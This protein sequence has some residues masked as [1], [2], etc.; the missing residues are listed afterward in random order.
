MVEWREVAMGGAEGAKGFHIGRGP[1]RHR[2]RLVEAVSAT[3]MGLLTII[4]KSRR[5]EREMRILFL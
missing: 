1:Y 5:K 4:R 3:L 2:G